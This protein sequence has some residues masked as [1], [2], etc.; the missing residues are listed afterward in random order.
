VAGR[1]RSRVRT[2]S[3]VVLV[4]AVVGVAACGT[5]AGKSTREGGAE[6]Q[7][8]LDQLDEAVRKNDTDFRVARLHPAVIERYGEEQCRDFIA[9]PQA[10]RDPSR[11]DKVERVDDPEP[12]DFTTD[13]GAVPIPDAQ[14]VL[15]KE[16]FKE[17]TSTRE[18]HVAKVDGEFRYFIDCGTPLM[19]Q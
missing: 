18:L 19:R 14:L 8:F 2:A 10:G 16:T 1:S 15:V 3:F 5:D 11:N 9:G 13:D 17:K 6:V 12:F 4:L 7:K